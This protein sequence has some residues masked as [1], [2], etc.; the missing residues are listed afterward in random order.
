MSQ[1][2]IFWE[3]WNVEEKRK[4]Y[5]QTKVMIDKMVKCEGKVGFLGRC[6]KLK[7]VPRTLQVR[8]E[9]PEA[10]TSRQGTERWQEAQ[11][12]GGTALTR[13]ALV[14]QQS[15]CCRLRSEVRRTEL[16]LE[17]CAGVQHWPWVEKRL[18]RERRILYK[19][20]QNRTRQRLRRLL[21]EAGRVAP[22]W[23]DS[24]GRSFLET[25]EVERREGKV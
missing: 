20:A 5:L 1:N 18:V 10:A 9:A 21:Q 24:S 8:N 4:S 25:S 6:L 12:R 2:N 15:E 11:V 19:R 16:E 13:E 14:L 23:L 3:F 17:Q 22:T 7:M